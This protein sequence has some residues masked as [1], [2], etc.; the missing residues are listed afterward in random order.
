MRRLLDLALLSTLLAALFQPG[1][2][3]AQ[4]PAEPDSALA[5]TFDAI[6]EPSFRAEPGRVSAVPADVQ[7]D[8]L[9]EILSRVY[10]HKMARA[11]DPTLPR[12]VVILDIDYTAMLHTHRTEEALRRVGGRY[13]ITELADPTSLPLLPTYDGDGFQRWV[14]ALGL[15]EKYPDLDWQKFQRDALGAEWA[16]D[17]RN[18]ETITPGLHEF[19]RRVKYTGG[20]VVF[21]T[22]RKEGEREDVAGLLAEAGIDVPLYMKSSSKK[23]PEWK[24]SMVAAI[25][26]EHGEVVAVVDDMKDNRDAIIG[27]LPGRDVLD[28]PIAVPGFTTDITP[29]ELDASPWRI[30][31]FERNR[32][33]PGT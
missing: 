12:A 13:G 23:T 9:A 26:A 8:T 2:A 19:L 18:S 11:E 33:D 16:S 4:C 31:T 15:R 5:A 22:G 32:V 27:A 20:T 30:S 29:D 14:D 17:L 6:P 25:E 28:V 24:A 1:P 7:R 3:Y 21:L 10:D